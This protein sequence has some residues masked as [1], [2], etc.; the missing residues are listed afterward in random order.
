MKFVSKYRT[1]MIFVHSWTTS[2]GSSDD[3]FSGRWL[4]WCSEG[5]VGWG[6]RYFV[7]PGPCSGT[8]NWMEYMQGAEILGCDDLLT[9]FRHVIAILFSSG[10]SSLMFYYCCVLQL[11]FCY[12]WFVWIKSQSCDGYTYITTTDHVM[13]IFYT[14]IQST[15]FFWCKHVTLLS[16]DLFWK[17]I[18]LRGQ[19]IVI[20]AFMVLTTT[21]VWL[22]VQQIVQSSRW[23]W[24]RCQWGLLSTS[25]HSCLHQMELIPVSEWAQREVIY[26]PV[27]NSIW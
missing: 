19:R 16:T 9:S 21:K 24:G 18:N 4:N 22:C 27:I 20:M 11:C 5:E 10:S 14:T 23:C 2:G 25:L 17:N 8:E 1:C 3:C 12:S 13:M 15:R 26:F 6:F 7:V